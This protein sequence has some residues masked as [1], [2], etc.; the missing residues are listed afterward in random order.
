MASSYTACI[1]LLMHSLG[2]CKTSWLFDAI[3]TV[4]PDT[5]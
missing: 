2:S 4:T 5:L 3:G 1:V